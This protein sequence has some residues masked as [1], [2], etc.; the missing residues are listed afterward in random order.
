A[1]NLK[2]PYS[3]NEEVGMEGESSNGQRQNGG[4]PGIAKSMSNHESL[5][6][7]AQMG[8]LRKS[9]NEM[10]EVPQG[11]Y[12]RSSSMGAIMYSNE[13]NDNYGQ[14]TMANSHNGSHNG[15]NWSAKSPSGRWA[16]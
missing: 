8:A 11:Q 9:G 13:N 14:H 5:K 4:K 3:I 1:Y 16:S 6:Y 12:N 7:C 10:G 2:I 15:G